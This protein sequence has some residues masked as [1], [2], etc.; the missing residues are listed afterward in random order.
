[1]YEWNKQIQIIVDEI[2]INIKKQNNEVLTLK[3]LSHK[4]RYSEFYMT[5][6]LKK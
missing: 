1:M 2:D 4:L 3:A 5:K 6:E